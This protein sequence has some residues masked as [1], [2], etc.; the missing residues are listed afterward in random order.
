MKFQSLEDPGSQNG[1]ASAL[2]HVH[3]RARSRNCAGLEDPACASNDGPRS[4]AMKKRSTYNCKN[5]ED[6]DSKTTTVLHLAS[7]NNAL[8][9]SEL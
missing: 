1:N 8:A 4:E 9:R 2:R 7:K 5:S 6:P 3:T